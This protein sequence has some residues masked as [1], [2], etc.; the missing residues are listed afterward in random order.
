MEQRKDA[1]EGSCCSSMERDRTC[2]ERS[3]LA[4]VLEHGGQMKGGK[5]VRPRCACAQL[6]APHARPLQ[7][8]LHLHGARQPLASTLTSSTLAPNPLAWE[9]RVAELF[10]L[11][12]HMT[13]P[14]KRFASPRPKLS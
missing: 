9:C 5:A 6:V 10:S 2:E 3:K 4:T 7:Q 1:K 14:V 12:Q 13:C 11:L 8:Q